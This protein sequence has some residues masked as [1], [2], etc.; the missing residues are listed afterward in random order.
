MDP[1]VPGKRQRLAIAVT[2]AVMGHRLLLDKQDIGDAAAR[3]LIMAGP[4]SHRI[5]L[6]DEDGR[7]VDQVLFTV[8]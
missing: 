1:D 5:T 8:R 4:G 7:R 6:M 3:P 2:G